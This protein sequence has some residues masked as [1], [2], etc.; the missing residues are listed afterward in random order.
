MRIILAALALMIG[1]AAWA[2]EVE[3]GTSASIIAQLFKYS[4]ASSSNFAGD[5]LI[6]VSDPAN[7]SICRGAFLRRSDEPVFGCAPDG[8]FRAGVG[9]AN[10]RVGRKYTALAGF[11]GQILLSDHS[12]FALKGSVGCR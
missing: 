10:P 3:V 5:L 4:D 6:D 7:S 2:A 8:D 12:G 11:L 9:C 1:N